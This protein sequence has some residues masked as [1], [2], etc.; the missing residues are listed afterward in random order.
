M[1]VE[2]IEELWQVLTIC[3]ALI[4]WVAGAGTR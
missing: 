2:Q 4:C 3:L 1:F